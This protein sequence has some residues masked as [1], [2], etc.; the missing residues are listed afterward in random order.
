[1][2]DEMMNLRTLLE[3]SSDADLL[4]KMIGFTVQRL[5]ELAPLHLTRC[6]KNFLHGRLVES[7]RSDVSNTNP[8]S[9]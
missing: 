5:M 6:R 9:R 2:T 1:M 7:A 8:L 4:R 3:K